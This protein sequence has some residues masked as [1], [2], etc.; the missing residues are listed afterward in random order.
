M[1]DM[2]FAVENPEE[3]HRANLAMNPDH[4]TML[5]PLSTK[6]IAYVQDK[7]GSGMWY[8]AMIKM[9]IKKF[10]NRLMKYGIISR[11]ALIEDLTQW[12]NLYAAGRLHKPVHIFKGDS[13]IEKALVTNRFVMTVMGS[14]ST[15]VST[16]A[17]RL[18]VV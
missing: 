13:K 8:N 10:P 1:V 11:T 14:G 15:Y 4:Y 5:I 17:A 7:F 3:W 2:V 12:T 16:V 9:K 6:M 18:N